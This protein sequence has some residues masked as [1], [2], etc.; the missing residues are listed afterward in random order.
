MTSVIYS[1][2]VTVI[3]WSQSLN[4]QNLCNNEKSASA[5]SPPGHFAPYLGNSWLLKKFFFLW[6]LSW[7]STQHHCS[8]HKNHTQKVDMTFFF[9][10]KKKKNPSKTSSIPSLDFKPS[11]P[12][13]AYKFP[14]HLCHFPLD[15]LYSSRLTN[16]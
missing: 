12:W 4:S 5:W 11:I 3:L 8:N 13:H 1:T 6:N 9:K 7:H 14:P 16:R 15:L 2:Q 10:C